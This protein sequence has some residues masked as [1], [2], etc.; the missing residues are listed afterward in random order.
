MM[1]LTPLNY[2]LSLEPD[3]EKYVFSGFL[4]LNLESAEKTVSV[5]LNALELDIHVCRVEVD[6]NVQDCAFDIDPDSE[7]LA[8]KLP[9]PVSGKFC[10]HI[11]YTGIIND[12]MAGFYR[13]RYISED[14]VYPIAVTQFQESDARRAF[15]CFDH[16]EKKSG[17]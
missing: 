3:L 10:L 16:P 1:N 9:E 14:K 12:K 8:I 7:F 4:E 15:P 5:C 2:K 13:S 11:K 6:N 17:V